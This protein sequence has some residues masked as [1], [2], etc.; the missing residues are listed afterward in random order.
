MGAIRDFASADAHSGD[1]T[2]ADKSIGIATF[3]IGVSCITALSDI[4]NIQTSFPT[5]KS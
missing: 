4:A 3:S 1:N 2:K 5:F